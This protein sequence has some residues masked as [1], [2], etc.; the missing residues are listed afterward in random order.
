MA[1]K[2]EEPMTDHSRDLIFAKL[3]VGKRPFPDA[4]L[5]INYRPMVPNI[6][7]DPAALTAR[8]VQE[9]EKVGCDLHHTANPEGAI[10]IIMQLIGEDSAISCWNLDTIP[11]PGLASAFDQANIRLHGQDAN[12]RVGLTGVDAALA[13]T[14]S[15]VLM[16]GNGR[17]RATSLLP[18]I[19]IA[20]V[21][22]DQI[23]P[24]LESWWAHQRK[25]GLDKT[26][27]SSNVVVISGPSRTADIA[28]QL[29][30]GMHG[31]MNLHIVLI[32]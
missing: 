25:S 6:T 20:V 11:I 30:M 14:G 27:Q 8:F 21:K 24:N 10:E 2:Q 7:G 23:L 28:M 31:P 18:L 3:R 17:F 26:T 13:A 16:S 4:K 9:A 12:V 1:D 5:P 15:V 19:H 29:V 22:S 32:P